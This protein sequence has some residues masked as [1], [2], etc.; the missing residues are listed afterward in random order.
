MAKRTLL[1]RLIHA[2]CLLFLFALA[3]CGSMP[4]VNSEEPEKYVLAPHA[5]EARYFYTRSGLRLFGQWWMPSGAPK[6]VVLLAHG[7]AV[8]S[9][10]YDPWASEL[11][12]RGYA[13]LGVD[14]RGWGQSQGFGRR[15]SVGKFDE[16]VEDV[17][18]ARREV[19]K[20]FPGK[21][22]YLQGES[23]GGAVVLM[24]HITGRVPSD[25]LL[26]N[27]PAVKLSPAHMLPGALSDFG[28]WFAA[29]GANLLPNAPW[30]PV[31]KSLT[32]FVVSDPAVKQRY[33]EDPLT[34]HHALPGTFLIAMQDATK[35]LTLNVNNVRAPFIVAQGTRDVMVPT[36][37]SEYLFN[38]AQSTDKTL[39]VYPGMRHA[40]LHDTDKDKVWSDM[41]AWLDAHAAQATAYRAAHPEESIEVSEMEH[42]S[43]DDG[44]T[45][46]RTKYQ[47]LTMTTRN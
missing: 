13:V 10:F 23:L 39:K 24:A 16:Y 26:L 25:G 2:L 40:T 19:A 28:L 3:G 34:A 4:L 15:G 30:L 5:N 42:D 31:P 9:G 14:L 33:W 21:P 47:Q 43:E 41:V 1:T 20:R 18:L 8:H 46:F 7:T 44:K 38:Q 29:Q 36:A 27:A 22:V 11:T 35:R 6:A 17:Y 45:A 12:A 37:A 32:G